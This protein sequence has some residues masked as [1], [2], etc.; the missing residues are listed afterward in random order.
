MIHHRVVK[1]VSQWKRTTKVVAATGVAIVAAA[2]GVTT[3]TQLNQNCSPHGNGGRFASVFGLEEANACPT[4]TNPTIPG[5][6]TTTTVPTTT[7][8]PTTTIPPG[9]ADYYLA[10]TPTGNDTNNCSV[11]SPCATYQRVNMLMTCGKVTEAADGT[12]GSQPT[13]TANPSRQVCS[14]ESQNAL[15]RPAAGGHMFLPCSQAINF[16]A[17][18]TS[19]NGPDWL[20]I[21]GVRSA[22]GCGSWAGLGTWPIEP[23]VLTI[24]FGTTHTRV[25]DTQL[26]N[27][28][29]TNGAY[30]TIGPNNIIG[31]CYT[32]S[33]AA[34]LAWPA[35]FMQGC[36]SR[37]IGDHER[38]T[39]TIT[40]HILCMDK[41]ASP[42]GVDWCNPPG[43]NGF[44]VDGLFIRG[45]L[46]CQ[47][48]HSQMYANGV[49]NI[50]WQDC[51][52]QPGSDFTS[53]YNNYFGPP[54][55]DTQ[56]T[57][58]DADPIDFD[59]P[60]TRHTYVG[61]NTFD[62]W[63]R[64]IDVNVVGCTGINSGNSN[65]TAR[66]LF[67]GNA[68]SAPNCGTNTDY[69][70]NVFTP[71]STFTV[72]TSSCFTGT[73][74]MINYPPVP[75]GNPFKFVTASRSG[76]YDIHLQAT[77]VLRNK[78]PATGV[79]PPQSGLWT[80]SCPPDDLYGT[81]RPQLAGQF[82]N[83]GAVQG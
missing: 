78:V 63:C 54:F 79:L 65:A 51:C 38:I 25:E 71:F 72:N 17:D 52:G 64:T 5:G 83:A 10:P 58:L 19:N 23:A 68:A 53:I 42:D 49:T 6:S 11:S 36:T 33:L 59:D 77:S 55:V 81:P 46:Y 60:P 4:P 20:T 45:C 30:N 57:I 15:I 22:F 50:R 44:H 16:G 13:V 29:M 82:C 67:V 18:S 70:Y 41:N 47:L 40:H 14:S 48:D 7:T 74:Q 69:Y 75:E 66:G 39:G 27:I 12:Y 35:Q 8:T 26:S 37:M 24:A 9:A 31:P 2:A 43:G 3:A 80:N 62:V 28:D 73:N 76:G 61:F 21:R 34:K 56:G 32:P 1:Y